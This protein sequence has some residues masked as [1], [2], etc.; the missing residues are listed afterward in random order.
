MTPRRETAV[1]VAW[2]ERAE[3]WQRF[4]REIRGLLID[5]TVKEIKRTCAIISRP[6][7]PL[8]QHLEC[9]GNGRDEGW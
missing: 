7:G 4:K 8:F 6:E 3:A 1:E 2:A 9:M 5:A